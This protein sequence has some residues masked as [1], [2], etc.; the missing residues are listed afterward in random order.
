MRSFDWT[1]GINLD[2]DKIGLWAHSVVLQGP[3][4]GGH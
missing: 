1:D 2:R 4:F 3:V